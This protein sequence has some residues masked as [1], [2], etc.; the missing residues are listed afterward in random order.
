[1]MRLAPEATAYR[2]L[3]HIAMAGSDKSEIVAII[4][5]VK[6]AGR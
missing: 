3:E 5:V 2:R 1:M 4:N 6:M